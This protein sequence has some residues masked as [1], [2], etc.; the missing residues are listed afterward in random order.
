MKDTLRKFNIFLSFRQKQGF[1]ILTVL[2]S[3]SALLEI[4]GIGMIP[5]FVSVVL[6]YEIFNNYV[7]KLNL[8]NFDFLLYMSQ[9]ELLIFMSIFIL[10]LFVFKN[11]FLMSIHYFQ[12][13][14][15]CKVTTNNSEK[16][17]NKYLY[18]D[19]SFHL[20]RN[21]STLIKNISNEINHSV[22]FLGSIL[23]L[24]REILIFLMICIILLI[25]S[26][27]SFTYIAG[28]FLCFLIFF[29]QLLKKRVSESGKK[30][31]E[32]RGNLVFAI[33][34]SLGFIKEVILLNKRDIFSNLFKKNLEI[35]EQQNIFLNI[36]NKVPRLTF[37]LIAVLIC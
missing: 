2:M 32:S 33:Q 22:T 18:S 5:V 20:D 10:G 8:T 4:I 1:F 35:T 26:P 14:F 27:M 37:E 36:I 19:Y 23:Y 21:S 12:A 15:T 28:I 17:Y 9:E 29:Y 31:Y 25:N 16:V 7:I 34:Q 13:L 11:I 30:F 24:L 3:I 6:D